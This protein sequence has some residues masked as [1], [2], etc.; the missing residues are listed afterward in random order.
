MTE[1]DSGKAV[2]TSGYT[3]RQSGLA[4]MQTSFLRLP[5]TADAAKLI[6]KNIIK[7]KL[8]IH[9]G[10]SSLDKGFP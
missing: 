4:K 5:G 7:A 2:R 8:Y 1:R 6:C 3:A 10:L 9:L